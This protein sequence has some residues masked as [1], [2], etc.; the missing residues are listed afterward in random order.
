MHYGDRS[1]FQHPPDAVLRRTALPYDI[2][3]SPSLGDVVPDGEPGVRGRV[4][5]NT[6]ESFSKG[7]KTPKAS[8]FQERLVCM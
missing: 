3:A 1:V 6:L 5:A 8:C 4:N 7:R 2:T